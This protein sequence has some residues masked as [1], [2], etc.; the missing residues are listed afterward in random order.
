MFIQNCPLRLNPTLISSKPRT[1][2]F[3]KQT[4]SYRLT[5][6]SL[7]LGTGFGGL[8]RVLS[9]SGIPLQEISNDNTGLVWWFG[10]G[11]TNSLAI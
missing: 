1:K 5:R 11:R 10:V 4:G 9:G 3:R 8:C 2:Y 7:G 6:G